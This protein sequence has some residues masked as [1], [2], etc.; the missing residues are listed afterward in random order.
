MAAQQAGRGQDQ[1]QR[2]GEE[3]GRDEEKAD[4]AVEMKM[5]AVM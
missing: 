4:V 1:D 3:G 2:R 5:E